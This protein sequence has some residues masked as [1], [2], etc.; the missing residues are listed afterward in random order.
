MFIYS[1]CY[2]YVFFIVMYS[3]CYV[4]IFLLC[5]CVILL[6]IL[7]VTYIYSYCFVCS[8]LGI[9]SLCFSVYLLCVNVYCTAA[10]GCQLQLTDLSKSITRKKGILNDAAAITLEL[11]SDM[12]SAIKL[13]EET[14]T[15]QHMY[16]R[17][18]KE[19]VNFFTVSNFF[20]VHGLMSR[21]NNLR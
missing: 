10:T 3:Y 1:Y 16:L 17:P 7:I 21:V 12:C 19:V 2:V 8:V 9:V 18:N 5:L 15:K 4:C 20:P 11:A 6:F 14:V 13:S